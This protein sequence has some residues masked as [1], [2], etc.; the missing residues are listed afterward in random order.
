MWKNGIEQP[1]RAVEDYV[2]FVDLAPTFL[3]LAGIS[4]NDAGMQPTIGKSLRD[5]FAGQNMI[6]RDHV[7]IGQERH[8]VGRPH[9][10]GY[11]IRGIVKGDMLYLHNFEPSRWPACNPETGYLNC[12]G[13][14]AKTEI[15]K[16][17]TDP[18]GQRFWQLCFGKR[19]SEELYDLKSDPDCVNNLAE[20]PE[21][22]SLKAQ[23]K[24]Q[25]FAE[26]KAQ[27][28]PRMFGRGSIF[29]E[30]PYSDA[31]LRGFYERYMAGEKLK[32]GWVSPSDFAPAPLDP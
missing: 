32:A 8:D 31:A 14:P 26:L 10:W 1:G 24:D 20:K 29:E 27:E 17:R 4:A 25:L 13:G 12:D 19:P 15:L 18:A 22:Q 9:D 23:L 7:L 21:H 3:E 16:G 28:D 6:G 2:S 5:L 30:Y 11:P